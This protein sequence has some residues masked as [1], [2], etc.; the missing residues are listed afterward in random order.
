MKYIYCVKLIGGSIKHPEILIR[1]SCSDYIK[2]MEAVRDAMEF[3]E[4]RGYASKECFNE[5]YNVAGWFRKD[6]GYVRAWKAITND[7]YVIHLDKV[8]LNN[9]SFKRWL[10]N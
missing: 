6:Q 2:A 10:R 7:I 4:Q 1:E 5:I 9:G 8:K 3:A